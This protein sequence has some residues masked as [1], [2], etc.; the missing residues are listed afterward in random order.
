MSRIGG[1]LT[2]GAAGGCLFLI[3]FLFWSCFGFWRLSFPSKPG[4]LILLYICTAISLCSYLPRHL[5]GRPAVRPLGIRCFFRF[6][7]DYRALERLLCRGEIPPVDRFLTGHCTC[8]RRRPGLCRYYSP[9]TRSN[10]PNRRSCTR[11][12]AGLNALEAMLTHNVSNE[13]IPPGRRF[14]I[15]NLR[16]C[17]PTP[18]FL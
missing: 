2:G 5:V 11:R 13:T 12:P 1:A 6:G 10:A 17:S 9:G 8:C 15:P 7:G 3:A 18:E 16:Y 4:V 14:Q